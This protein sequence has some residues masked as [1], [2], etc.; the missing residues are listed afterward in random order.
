M[1]W[2]HCNK[3]FRQDGASFCVTNCGHII[4]EK[5][6]EKEKCSVC[7]T[8]CRNLI[9]SNDMTPQVKMYF[10]SLTETTQRYL[11]HVA[12]VWSFQKKQLDRLVSFY[13]HK[14][15]KMEAIV[16][17]ARQKLILQEKEFAVLKKEN[18]ELKKL[19]SILKASPS[20]SGR[21]S[22][23][24][25]VA[26]TSPTNIVTPWRNNNSQHSGQ[27]V[28]R[29]GSVDSLTYRVSRSGGQP[30]SGA[31]SSLSGRSSPQEISTGTPSAGAAH[32]LSY[33]SSHHSSVAPQM[34]NF[35]YRAPLE[36]QPGSA[37][38]SRA[39]DAPQNQSRLVSPAG[40][41]GVTDHQ[42]TPV[43][44][45]QRRGPIQLS[46]TPRAAQFRQPAVSSAR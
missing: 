15:S 42:H 13:K 31:P 38:R 27:V 41:P 11:A 9:L 20:Q 7:G 30:T 5:C 33:R 45:E 16:H 26:I 12:Q 3:C 4:C 44:A 6:S 46:F 23:P 10:T 39:R 40:I 21:T 34:V 35:S 8:A 43:Q 22:T 28:S 1:D 14:V 29:A 36:S 18:A 24:R 37:L 2:F 17:E 32:G 19:L 25:Q